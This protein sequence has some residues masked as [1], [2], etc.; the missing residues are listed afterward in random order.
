MG[1]INIHVIHH[2][3]PQ[4]CHVHYPAL[5]NILKDVCDEF[6]LAYHENPNFFT[7]LKRHYL[8]LKQLGRPD[9]IAKPNVIPAH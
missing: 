9:G 8:L 3:L 5:T 6:G 1:G 2:I 7:A 4:V